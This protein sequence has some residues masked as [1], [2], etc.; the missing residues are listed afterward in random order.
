MIEPKL[1]TTREKL[2]LSIVVPLYNE[3]A[4]LK[5]FFS[6]LI[7]NISR[8]NYEIIFVDDGSCDSSLEILLLLSVNNKSIK[9]V[10]LK[11]NLGQQIAICTGLKHARGDC[12][13]VLDADL[14]DPPH[15][16]HQM[17]SKWREG[18]KIV[19]AQRVARKDNF[20]KQISAFI[21]Y[22]LYKFFVNR[23]A[24]LDVGDFYLLDKEVVKNILESKQARYFLR[25][26]IAKQPLL[27]TQIL[28]IREA[29]LLGKT[30]YSV[31]K[32]LK[33]AICAFLQANIKQVTALETDYVEQVIYES[34]NKSKK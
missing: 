24:L 31:I 10:K 12:V 21:F 28:I 14:Q 3:K 30:K 34:K 2:F 9:I 29:R 26:T 4:V 23:K 19:F 5:K 16:I 27:H 32:M 6:T 15:Y 1:S 25:G 8:Y 7:K 20:V 33:L 17:I 22:R 13:I 18:Y 11:R